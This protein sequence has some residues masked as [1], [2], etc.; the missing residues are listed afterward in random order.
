ML[1]FLS[2]TN[3]YNTFYESEVKVVQYIIQD[4]SSY[5]V[6]IRLTTN[7]YGIK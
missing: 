5:C 1:Y 3:F 7:D 4:K 6:R 2:L